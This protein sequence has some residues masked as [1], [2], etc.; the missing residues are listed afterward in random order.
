MNI[1]TEPQ[2]IYPNIYYSYMAVCLYGHGGNGQISSNNSVT[3][4][5]GSGGMIW[6]CLYPPLVQYVEVVS[7][8][9]QKGESAKVIVYEKGTGVT[10]EYSANAG[11]D[12]TGSNPGSG[13]TYDLASN[14]VPC[15]G[16]TCE[17][18]AVFSATAYRG[19]SGGGANYGGSQNGYTASG[20]GMS[21]V[22][23]EYI[24]APGVSISHTFKGNVTVSS[25]GSGND[26]PAQNYGAGGAGT[27][28]DYKSNPQLY[29]SGSTGLVSY[30]YY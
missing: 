26:G 24:A 22:N 1:V 29:A 12:A 21:A 3:A 15:S 6:L 25:K 14:F 5:G 2:K 27:P 16:S 19:V 7:T 30:Y 9:T 11:G 28:S 8:G 17:L 4:G 23:R 20:S 13:G 18:K 10:Y